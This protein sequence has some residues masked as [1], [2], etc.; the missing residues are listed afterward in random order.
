MRHLLMDP[1]FPDLVAEQAA[2]RLDRKAKVWTITRGADGRLE[3]RLDETF[4]EKLEEDCTC[5]EI[6]D[7]LITVAAKQ[8]I[9]GS[10]T[11]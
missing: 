3:E 11:W 6:I 8:D 1:A 10:R 2:G 4:L 5:D 7:A 9:A